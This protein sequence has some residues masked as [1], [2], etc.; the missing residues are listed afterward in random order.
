MNGTSAAAMSLSSLLLASHV[1][2][3]YEKKKDSCEGDLWHHVLEKERKT[4]EL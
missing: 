1:E 3:C 2:K 4:K